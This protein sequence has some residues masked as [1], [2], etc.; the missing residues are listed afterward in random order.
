MAG[1]KMKT[2]LQKAAL[3]M[4]SVVALVGCQEANK[5]SVP[6]D[7]RVG[8]PRTTGGYPTNA[9]QSGLQL[10]GVVYTDSTYQ[11]EFNEAVR[12]FMEASVDDRSYVGYVSA[13]SSN[14]TGVYI[15]GRV[16][17]QGGQSISSGGQGNIDPRS[18]L[19]VGVFDAWPDLG[20]VPSLPQ[21]YF[22]QAQG[23]IQGN[24][25]QIRFSDDNGWV[26]MVGTFD[27][28][29]FSGTFSYDVQRTATGQTGHAGQMGQFEIP[30]CKF[31]VCQ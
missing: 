23:V 6:V 1:I 27:A 8:Y 11:N 2:T 25:A 15:G 22:T 13:S 10:N 12:D 24:Q 19:V 26:E 28:N 17:L 14:D 30:T 5:G 31:F 9:S 3:L 29:T 18:Q 4:I 21:P 20:K 16:A 7:S